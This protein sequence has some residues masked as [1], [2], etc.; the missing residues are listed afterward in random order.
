VIRGTSV[1]ADGKT[2]SITQPSSAAQAE[3][4]NQAYEDAGLDQ[5]ETDYCECHGTGTPVGDPLE[6]T[7]IAMTLGAAR[8]AAGKTPLYVGS[9]KPTVGHTEGCAGLAGIFKSI[10]LLASNV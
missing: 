8:R 6:L 1:N 3:L 7:A 9:I 5:S 10:L 2:P 4:I